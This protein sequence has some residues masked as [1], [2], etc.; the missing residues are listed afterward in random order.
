MAAK[1]SAGS[2]T[3]PTPNPPETVENAAPEYTCQAEYISPLANKKNIGKRW[4]E[5]YY[6]DTITNEDELKEALKKQLHDYP[7]VQ[8]TVDWISFTRNAGGFV[9]DVRVGN[10]GWLRDR[11]GTDVSVRIQSITQVLDDS[12]PSNKGSITFG[13]KIFD[14]SVWN[15]RQKSAGVTKEQLEKLQRRINQLSNI[16]T[17]QLPTMNSDEEATL[18]DYLK[19]HESESNT[20]Q[21]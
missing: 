10:K 7:D 18:D 15:D 1:L 6:S 11:L 21:D 16:T 4:A 12:D 17:T 8:Y 14:T 5:P 3:T 13:N 2:T 9:N 19:S 20:S